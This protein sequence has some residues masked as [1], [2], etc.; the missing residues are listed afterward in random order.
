MC[1]VFMHMPQKRQDRKE[2][3][4]LQYSLALRTSLR[5]GRET[6]YIGR[7]RRMRMDT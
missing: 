6:A 3:I 1:L 7:I 4:F 2:K 5:Q